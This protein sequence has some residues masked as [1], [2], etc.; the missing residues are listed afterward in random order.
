VSNTTGSDVVLV[1]GFHEIIELCETCGKSIVGIIDPKLAGE[2]LGYRVLGA[3]GD[4]R[5]LSRELQHVPLV[6]VPDEPAV[7]RRLSRLY[8]ELGFTFSC[9][10]HPRASISRSARV[11]SGAIIQD[12]VNISSNV[13]I[14]DFVKV[15]SQANIM[16]DTVVG[17]FTSIA[18][19][20][21]LLGRVE[22]GEACYVGANA[23]VLPNIHIGHEA[24][25]GAAAVVTRNVDAGV[26]VVGNPARPAP[27]TVEQ[28]DTRRLG[29]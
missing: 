23:T 25:I 2:Y 9:L 20:A 14:N 15:N 17:S 19:N 8:A 12:G 26:T 16:H 3:D 27:L 11:G 10:V 6:L 18:P 7:R 5:E 24:V 28:G 13:I 1:G 21:V 4:A 29:E 22:V